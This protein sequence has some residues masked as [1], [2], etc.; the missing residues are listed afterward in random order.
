MTS[1]IFK[2]NDKKKTQTRIKFL[3]VKNKIHIPRQKFLFQAV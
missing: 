2:T 1:S 3:A